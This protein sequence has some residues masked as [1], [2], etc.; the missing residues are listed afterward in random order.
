MIWAILYVI[1]RPN[2]YRAAI[3]LDKLMMIS[4]STASMGI[5]DLSGESIDHSLGCP[6]VYE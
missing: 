6:L 2:K 1:G 5:G 4:I 3:L